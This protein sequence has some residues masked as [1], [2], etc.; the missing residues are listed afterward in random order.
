MK[1]Y[2]CNSPLGDATLCIVCKKL[3]CKDCIGITC[4]CATCSESDGTKNTN[5]NS[6]IGSKQDAKPERN[7][8]WT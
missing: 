2:D 3:F 1:C 7:S 5:D 4:I 8:K 6:K